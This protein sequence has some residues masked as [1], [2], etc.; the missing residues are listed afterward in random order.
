MKYLLT[1]ES[2]AILRR[3]CV[4]MNVE[5]CTSVNLNGELHGIVNFL[6]QFYFRKVKKESRNWMAIVLT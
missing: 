2:L 6:D 1:N 4:C 5:I 3:V